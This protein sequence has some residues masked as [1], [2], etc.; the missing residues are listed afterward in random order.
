MVAYK[1]TAPR[2]LGKIPKGFVIQVASSSTSKP[3]AQEV[4][5]AI[6]RAGFD[7]NHSR[8]YRCAGNWKVEKLG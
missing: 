6:V 8:S 5:A 4:E 1:L 7:D 3:S 2:Q